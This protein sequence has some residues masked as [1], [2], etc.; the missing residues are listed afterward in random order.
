MWNNTRK[1]MVGGTASRISFATAVP[2]FPAN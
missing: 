2:I 1:K